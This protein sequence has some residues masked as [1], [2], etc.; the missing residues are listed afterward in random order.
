MKPLNIYGLVLCVT[1]WTDE[2]NC[3]FVIYNLSNNT[4]RNSNWGR[5]RAEGYMI[6]RHLTY[7]IIGIIVIFG[8]G[9]LHLRPG[10]V[11]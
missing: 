6:F 4:S 3:S 8:K 9:G 11:Q 10:L 2:Q 7:M 5:V 1:A